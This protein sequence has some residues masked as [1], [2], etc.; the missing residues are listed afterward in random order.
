MSKVPEI[1]K[2]EATVLLAMMSSGHE[3]DCVIASRTRHAWHDPFH[4]YRD[5]SIRFVPLVLLVP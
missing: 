3:L 4:H 1:R 5:R 2:G